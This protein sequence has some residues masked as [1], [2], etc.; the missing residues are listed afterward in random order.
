MIGWMV[1]YREDAEK[2]RTYIQ[3]FQ[4][5]GKL[6][7]MMIELKIL[8]ELDGLREQVLPDFVLNRSRD[9]QISEQLEALGVRCVNPAEVSRIANDKWETYRFFKKHQIPMLPTWG[10]IVDNNL[11]KQKFC[12]YPLVAKS[13]DGHGGSE[14]FIVENA[15]AWNPVIEVLFGRKI[16][17]QKMCGMIGR[18]LRIFVLGGEA[19]AAVLRQSESD[20]RA[21]YSLGGQIR[22]AELTKEQKKI[23]KKICQVFPMEWG[24]ID[25]LFDSEDHFY[26][27]EVEDA[28]GSRSLSQL[29]ELNVARMVLSY[30]QRSWDV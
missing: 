5:E 12:G 14:V 23:V 8:E 1:Y 9:A 22:L 26:L 6:L 16:V 25:L 15:E 11:K 18:D 19:I 4:A 20:F 21:N 10:A 28:V 7:G 27:N 24:G 3:W 13:V 29:T 17:I 2:N 30:I